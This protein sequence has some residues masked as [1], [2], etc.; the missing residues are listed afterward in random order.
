MAVGTGQSEQFLLWYSA[1]LSLYFSIYVALPLSGS[2][3]CA[4]IPPSLLMVPLFFLSVSL[5]VS[6]PSLPHSV[7]IP[8][9]LSFCLTFC[10]SSF[11][12]PSVPPA[13]ASPRLIPI[14]SLSLLIPHLSLLHFSSPLS[15]HL[16]FSLI[17]CISM[18]L[19][20]MFFT[21]LCIPLG[22]FP[23]V[24]CIPAPSPSF[25]PLVFLLSLFPSSS[26]VLILP[27]CLSH[28]YL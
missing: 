2:L 16:L 10:Y 28:L 19:L 26:L 1:V 24:Y 23:S 9:S 12:S 4:S 20:S 8:L 21:A 14:F 18:S 15:L 6:T 17:P 3:C 27:L 11:V 7:S 22:V 13:A 5:S 25:P